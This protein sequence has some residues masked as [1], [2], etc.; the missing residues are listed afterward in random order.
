[1]YNAGGFISCRCYVN[2]FTAKGY[3]G[4]Y[5][6]AYDPD[7]YNLNIKLCQNNQNNKSQSSI[8]EVNMIFKKEIS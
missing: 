7:K 1:L 6:K 5:K 4:S 2:T 8:S 3:K